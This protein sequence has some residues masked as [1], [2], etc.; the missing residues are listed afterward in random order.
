MGEQYN[1]PWATVDVPHG[2]QI[3][4]FPF[5]EPA[6]VNLKAQPTANQGTVNFLELL[7]L[8]RPFFWRVSCHS[9]IE[10]KH[11]YID[12][13]FRKL[14]LFKL[15][16][17]TPCFSSVFMNGR[18][19]STATRLSRS[20]R[21][22]RLHMRRR[23]KMP[24]T[25]KTLQTSS[26]RLQHRV[27]SWRSQDGFRRRP[28]SSPCFSV[29]RNASRRQSSVGLL[30]TAHHPSPHRAPPRDTYRRHLQAA[31]HHAVVMMSPSRISR[32]TTHSH[33]VSLP[34]LHPYRPM[35]H[36]A[37][38]AGPPLR[39]QDILCQSLAHTSRMTAPKCLH[40]ALQQHRHVHW[41]TLDVVMMP[42]VV[43]VVV[44]RRQ[45]G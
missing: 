34:C 1:V 20:S 14:Q 11:H 44:D 27:P 41:M 15:S 42:I 5:V 29:G 3:Q 32:I 25:F 30:L 18:S 45:R 37:L 36:H 33:H 2:L 31:V 12:T 4:L 28:S 23:V 9:Y 19:S 24:P 40:R 26:A 39:A 10:L 17:R 38:R 7:Q 13:F 16:S 8:L 21:D 43:V 35:L 6:L 22:G